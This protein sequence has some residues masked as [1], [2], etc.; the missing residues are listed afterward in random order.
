MSSKNCY[1]IAKNDFFFSFKYETCF[2]SKK[3]TQTNHFSAVLLFFITI[4]IF[5]IL[6]LVFLLFFFYY[7]GPSKREQRSRLICRVYIKSLWYSPF[8]FILFFF[9]L[10]FPF[11]YLF[12]RCFLTLPIYIFGFSFL[13]TKWFL[14]R[15]LC[16]SRFIGTIS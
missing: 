15:T 8:I 1:F 16:S 3:T 13:I 7:S 9:F 11:L 12:G 4:I 10:H 5:F 14:R 6:H 2:S